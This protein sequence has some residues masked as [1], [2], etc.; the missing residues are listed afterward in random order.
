MTPVKATQ[1]TRPLPLFTGDTAIGVV[2]LRLTLGALAEDSR[3][4]LVDWARNSL[5]L[6]GEAQAGQV[7]IDASCLHLFM[8]A[9]NLAKASLP[10]LN[11]PDDGTLE[12]RYFESG[13][14]RDCPAQLVRR[15]STRLYVRVGGEI[16][17]FDPV[18]GELYG[19]P[20]NPLAVH[21]KPEE[22]PIFKARR[23]I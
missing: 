15:T 3:P 4:Q 6:L 10:L 16:H 20:F 11:R 21:L 1:P 2:Q 18:T 5:A 8:R 7:A 12:V 17:A 13:Y 14:C 19:V 9:A 23:P 22:K